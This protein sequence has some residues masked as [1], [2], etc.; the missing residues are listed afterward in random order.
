[1]SGEG[2]L[3]SLFIARRTCEARCFGR[4]LEECVLA[5]GRMPQQ[6]ASSSSTPTQVSAAGWCSHPR[7]R[8]AQPRAAVPELPPPL[9]SGAGAPSAAAGKRRVDF[10]APVPPSKRAWVVPGIGAGWLRWLAQGEREAREAEAAA[11]AEAEAA[12]EA[13]RG[14]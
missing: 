12:A 8:V 5:L 11:A 10:S 6:A 2:A 14:G 3:I 1:M 7:W 4:R 9:E 13:A